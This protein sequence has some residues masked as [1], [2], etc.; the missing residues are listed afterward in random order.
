MFFIIVIDINDLSRP[1]GFLL[2]RSSVGGSVASAKAANVSITMLTQRICTAFSGIA[3]KTRDRISL[4]EISGF[5]MCIYLNSSG[6]NSTENKS[7]KI[8]S[9]LELKKLGNG[10]IDVSAP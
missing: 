1:Y 8:S 3:Y 5:K 4:I 2:R 9:E 6:T 7:G 10:I